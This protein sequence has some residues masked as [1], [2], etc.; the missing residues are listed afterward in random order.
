MPDRLIIVAGPTGIGK[1]KLGIELALNFNTEIIS[2]DSRQI[3]K[4]LKI[5]VASPTDSQLKLVKHN[6]V[7]T[8]SI[9]EY[10]N[11]SMFEFE[12]LELLSQLFARSDKVIMVGGSGLYIDAVCK[13][14]DDLPTIDPMVR[15]NLYLNF[16]EKGLDFLRQELFK[17][18]PVYY[19]EVDLS[20]PKRM[21]KALE[22]IK[23]TNRPYSS[24][25]LKTKKKREFSIIKF[26]LD[27]P[28]NELYNQI[29]LRVDQMIKDGLIE[30][31][32]KLYPYRHLNAL[33][34]VGYKE[35]F[36]YFDGN[37]S[38]E[39][40]ISTIKFNTHKYARK[41]LTWFRK[42]E[43]MIWLN[44]K[45]KELMVKIIRELK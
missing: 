14:I 9:F 31:A 34:T 10:Y 27:K 41:Q 4:E 44:P 3:Y 17:L 2:A 22:V 42:D 6:F 29:D 19:N 39:E 16:N 15:K 21:L 13:G 11:A 43:E 38:I 37:S 35:L 28:R 40:A 45:E 30:E 8:R 32:K 36:N 7:G 25:L 33:N 1:T 26:A 12:V 5:G 18:D 20:N 24:F 23:M